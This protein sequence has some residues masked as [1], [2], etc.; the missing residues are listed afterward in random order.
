MKSSYKINLDPLKLY[1]EFILSLDQYTDFPHLD[2][3]K[4]QT[5]NNLKHKQLGYDDLASIMYLNSK[6]NEY[7][8]YSK[9]KCVFID[10]AQDISSLMFLSLRKIFRSASFSIFGDIAQGIYSYQAI[11]NWDE[12]ID[13]IGECELLYL[14]RSYR[15]SIEIMEDA[16]K[17][18]SLLGFAPANNVVRHGDKVDYY[19]SKD[20][21]H[22]KSL[23]EQ[24][25]K[26]FSH[27]AII[28]KNKQEL[29]RALQELSELNLTIL[30][31]SNLGYNNN[32]NTILTVQTAKGLEFNSVIIYNL[33]T[34]NT[35]NPND[36]KLLYVAKTRALHK[37]IINGC[38]DK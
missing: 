11:H 7:P 26:N 16:N 38:E 35:N 10:E 25:N 31:E 4:K 30:D 34:Y 28:C 6:I 19:H 1:K 23:L 12:V 36:L 37:L 22:I 13:I 20:S 21:T 17:T 24:L 3:L 33:S 9:L 15:T 14:T 32:Q 18:L 2:T 27:T 5:L 8:Y 29:E